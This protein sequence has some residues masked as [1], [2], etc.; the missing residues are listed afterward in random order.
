MTVERKTVHELLTEP[1]GPDDVKQ[2]EGR[3]GFRFDYI[4]A[5]S[6]HQRL[7]DVVGPG[8]WQ[9]AF[10]ILDPDS[11]AVECRLSVFIEGVWVAKADVGYPN[12]AQD[13]END[14]QEPLKAA[15]SDALKRAGVQFGIGRHLYEKKTPQRP[16][17]RPATASQSAPQSQNRQQPPGEALGL[18]WAETR[19]KGIDRNDVMAKAEEMFGKAPAELSSIERAGVLAAFTQ[20]R[21]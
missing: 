10:T 5:R 9:T 20:A 11:K 1:F 12:S 13:A 14:A 17:Q 8:G 16:A 6:V 15:Y 21:G 7:D 4:D 2:R 18:W 19:A 3:G